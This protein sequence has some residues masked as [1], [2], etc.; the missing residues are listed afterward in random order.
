MKNISLNLAK[1]IDESAQKKGVALP[2]G[3]IYWRK[4]CYSDEWLIKT[5]VQV[6]NSIYPFEKYVPAYTTDELLEL[7]KP[8]I[9]VKEFVVKSNSVSA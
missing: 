8:Q 9:T 2:E 6:D 1:A 7:L 5:K 4:E 3:R